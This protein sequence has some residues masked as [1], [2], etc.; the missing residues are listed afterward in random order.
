MYYI[1]K[2]FMT[3]EMF[4]KEVYEKEKYKGDQ[5]WRLMDIRILV[6]A[7]RIREYFCGSNKDSHDAMTVNDWLWGGK[8][9]FRGFR[10]IY[11]DKF[12]MEL[13]GVNFSVTSQHN[14]GRGLDYTFGKTPTEAV[15]QDILQNPNVKRYELVTGLELNTSWVHN[16]TRNWIK[17]IS[18]IYTFNK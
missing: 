10:H 15:Q 13:Q 5:I 18:G 17:N 2:Y 4:S 11:I 1:P 7:D 8:R 9:Q 12:A 6:T 16:D 3:Q 14:F